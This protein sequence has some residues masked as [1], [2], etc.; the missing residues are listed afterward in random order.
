MLKLSSTGFKLPKTLISRQNPKEH[1]IK[2]VE[3]ESVYIAPTL[4]KKVD[5]EELVPPKSVGKSSGRI[6]DCIA[7]NV[8][9]KEVINGR[10]SKFITN[11]VEHT[12]IS[13]IVESIDMYIF[14]NNSKSVDNVYEDVSR[15]SGIFRSVVVVSF[16][17]DDLD[18]M[19]IQNPS[20]NQKCG[21]YGFISG[22]YC[23]FMKTM[24][25]CQA[26]NTTLF[27]ETDCILSNGWLETLYNY[28][29]N[30]GGFWI[31]GATYDGQTIDVWKDRTIF[32]HLNGV[33]LYATGNVDFQAFLELFETFFVYAIK[34]VYNKY[35]YDHCIRVMVDYFLEKRPLEYYWRFVDRNLIRS[36]Y[37]I[38]CST[39]GDSKML[40]DINKLYDH[41]ILH[42]KPIKAE[43]DVYI[44]PS[45]R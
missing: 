5:I 36:Q 7:L 41:A 16:E 18:D 32:G 25:Y 13:K 33:A 43:V 26:Y 1:S 20:T 39:S 35:G 40:E 27:L 6:L 23:M 19:Y 14:L 24:E 31:S 17:L 45:K 34:N 15:I 21:K 9:T 44:L 10:F 42:I 28:T 8:T 29:K 38:N 11:I 22:P 2:E 30:A 37:I 4:P 12:V 3:L